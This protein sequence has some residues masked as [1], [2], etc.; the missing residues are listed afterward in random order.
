MVRPPCP[1][2]RPSA[3]PVGIGA[4]RAKRR[5]PVH[6]APRVAPSAAFLLSWAEFRLAV[7]MGLL[8]GLAWPYLELDIPV[9]RDAPESAPFGHI[10]PDG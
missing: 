1:S 10:Y 9:T 3:L 7:T 6:V 5:S 8:I 2:I 4:A